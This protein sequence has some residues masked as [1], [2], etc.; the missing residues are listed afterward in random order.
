MIDKT[1]HKETFLIKWRIALICLFLATATLAVYWQVKNHAFVDFD[2]PAY[3]TEN[4]YVHDGVNLRSVNW[5]FN[6]SFKE[7]KYWHPLTWISH[8]LDCQLFGL[9]PGMHHLTNLVLHMANAIL[10]FLVF[11]TMTGS[12]WR[13][14]FVAAVFALHPLNVDSVAW[15]AERK[16]VLSTFF[17]MLTLLAYTHYIKQPGLYRY[18]LVLLLFILGLMAKPMLVTLPFVLL[19]LDYWPLGRLQFSQLKGERALAFR[20][21]LEKV[22]LLVLSLVT[23]Y[24]SALSLKHG[25]VLISTAEVPM[26]LRTANALVSYVIYIGK[27][28]WPQNLAIFYPYP[29]QMLPLWQ[30]MGSGLFLICVTVLML[31]S[32]RRRPYLGVGWLWYLGMLFPFTGLM[33]GGLW[34]AMADRW[35]YVPLIGLF[36]L[37]AWGGPELLAKL[38]FRRIGLAMLALA[39]LSILMKT[40]WL[41]VRYWSDSMTLFE[42]ALN[43]TTGNYV[44]HNNL[45][46]CLAA[47]GKTSEAMSHY[48]E[49]LNIKSDCV[50][51]H[52]N[53]GALLAEH[54]RTTEAITHYS[55]ALR[56]KPDYVEALNNLGLALTRQGRMVEAIRHYSNA[57]RKRSDS[58]LT[59]NNMGLALDKLGRTS[60][61]INHYSEALRIKPDYKEALNNLGLAKARQGKREEAVNH[62][63]EVLRIDPDYAEAHNNMGNA[64]VALGKVDGAIDQYTEALRINPAYVK[65]LN[66]LGLALSEKGRTTE[67]I[68]NLQKALELDAQ[69]PSLHHNLANLYKKQGELDKALHQYKKTLS[70]QP[71]NFRALNS[72]A[73]VYAAKMEYDKALSLFKKI[74]ELRPNNADTY[75]NVACI[76]A[77]TNRIEDSVSWLKKAV[78][79]GYKDWDVI[80]TDMGL[81]NIR[82]SSYYKELIRGR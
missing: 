50:L 19:L 6:F 70:I 37:I 63:A 33:Q 69:N 15:V 27:M 46:I 2:D 71:T 28:I 1:T 79:R 5:A 64:L 56:I 77:R 23:I 58:E 7:G 80:K 39:L 52:N 3:V 22:P 67:A 8:M 25:D 29:T 47:Q 40:T 12:V 26:N 17:W 81:E 42:H 57:L 55:E 10:L 66:N 62:Y 51:A 36:I 20:L 61:A 21:V 30:I 34:P 82:N 53:L 16:N 31:W 41:Q 44:A 73:L 14:A 54:G 9:R 32:L 18:G 60:E 49:A 76:Y 65:A 11:H 13:C 72:L 35:T 45:A 59:H 48:L 43:V 78:E 4:K 24:L 68:E 74:I 38:R 75:Y